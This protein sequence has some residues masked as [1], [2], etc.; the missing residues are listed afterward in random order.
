MA[1]SDAS[2]LAPT[3]RGAFAGRSDELAALD[4]WLRGPARPCTVRGVAGIGK[5]RLALEF[6]ARH[7]G[8]FFVEVGAATPESLAA[9][10]ALT[11]GVE[12]PSTDLIACCAL[13]GEALDMRGEALV[14][15]DA[16][17]ESPRAVCAVWDVLARVATKARWLCTAQR[18]PGLSDELVIDLGPLRDDDARALFAARVEERREALTPHDLR[19]LP[20]LLDRLDRVPLAIELAAARVGLLDVAALTARFEA[21]GSALDR[22]LR[23]SWAALDPAERRA[24]RAVALFP[25][26]VSAASVERALAPAEGDVALDLLQRLIERSWLGVRTAPDG[27]RLLVLLDQVRSFVCAEQ[28]ADPDVVRAFVRDHLALARRIRG[29]TWRGDWPALMGPACAAAPALRAALRMVDAPGEAAEVTLALAEM[30]ELQGLVLRARELHDEAAPRCEGAPPALAF[31]L[32][33]ARVT[34]ERYGSAVAEALARAV[35]LEASLDAASPVDRAI[36]GNTRSTLLR[37]SGRFDEALAWARRGAAEAHDAG[38]RAVAA[39]VA[40]SVGAALWQLNDRAGALAVLEQAWHD[41]TATGCHAVEASAAL[42][43]GEL[44]LDQGRLPEAAC[45]LAAAEGAA[46]RLR[47]QRVGALALQRRALVELELGRVDV[48]ERLVASA[49]ARQRELGLRSRWVECLGAGVLVTMRAGRWREAL[50]RCD[51]A[52]AV[53]TSTPTVPVIALALRLLRA[54]AQHATGDRD[55]ARAALEECGAVAAR[56]QSVALESLVASVKRALAGEAVDDRGLG[57][58]ER[59]SIRLARRAAE[60]APA[61]PVL[62]VHAAGAW[63]ERAG[64]ERV[65]LAGRPTVAR[66]L[67][68]LAASPEGLDADGLLRAGWPGERPLGGSGA[69][70]VYDVVRTLRRLGLGDAIVREGG[71]YRLHPAEPLE[72]VR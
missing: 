6:A 24:L 48:A 58:N 33:L 46:E 71:R 59:M 34:C 13:L 5:T 17:E 10:I 66:V 49:E 20:A 25:G 54:V 70:R 39:N 19:A 41:A 26:P 28:P 44:L 63:F 35:A 52:L 67:A 53:T 30:Y 45:A 37:A 72:R 16:C 60:A 51:D 32:S 64:G 61:R 40:L 15:L 2:T 22:A 56:W 11:L 55:A 7:R 18:A 27:A 3:C 65:S 68:A 43:Y 57:Y 50:S 47:L 1:R 12:L 36:Y 23:G 8:G 42:N 14:I 31:A 38:L 9:G 4:A 69:A 62:R 21:G 29:V